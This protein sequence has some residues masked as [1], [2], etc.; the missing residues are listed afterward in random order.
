MKKPTVGLYLIVKDE[1]EQVARLVTSAQDHAVFDE[2]NITVSDKSTADKLSK[3]FVEDKGTNVEYRKWNDRFDEA[4]NFNWAQGST[5]FG[6]WCDADDEFDFFTIPM[7]M[8]RVINE[9]L[10]VIWLPYE[11]AYDENGNCV[12]RHTRERLISRHK[13]FTWRGWVHE[14]MISDEIYKRGDDVYPVKHTNSDPNHS[15]KRNLAILEKAYKETNDP[16]YVHYLGITYFTEGRYQE[17]IDTLLE[18]IEVGGW[19]EEIYRSLLRISDSYNQLDK[20]EEAV[21]FALKA[22]SVMPDYPDAFFT[23]AQIEFADDNYKQC[24]EWLKVAFGKQRPDSPSITDPTI[25]DRA[26]F[27]GAISEFQMRNYS[28]ALKLL[29]TVQTIDTS[30]LKPHYEAEANADKLANILPQLLDFYKDPLPLWN[31]LPDYLKYDNRFRKLRNSVTEPKVWDKK[32]IIIF[33]GKGYE[34]WGPHTLDKGMGGSEEAIVYLSRELVKQGYAVTVYGEVKE[35]YTNSVAGEYGGVNWLPWQMID[36][37]DQFDTL[38]VWRYPNLAG[39]FKANRLLIDMHDLLPKKQVIPIKDATYM[40]KSQWHKD[41]YPNITN[42]NIVSNG[43]VL[44]QF[45]DKAKKNPTSVGYFSAYYRGLEHV[46]KLWP[47]IKE[48]VPEATLDIFYGWESWTSFQGKDDFYKRMTAMLEDAKAL[49]VTEHGRVSHTELAQAMLKTNVWAYPTEF[50]EIFA[51]TAVKANAAH[52]IPVTTDRAALKETAGPIARIL[53]TDLFYT[54]EYNQQKFVDE[55]V[56]ALKSGIT[57]EEKKKQD[58]F[59]KQFDYSNVAR[60]WKDA[61]ENETQN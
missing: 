51:I 1:Y 3:L 26:R 61:I 11:Y 44:D 23:L 54:D 53:E 32:S 19:D 56:K 21:Q 52:C 27:I 12:A 30:E 59:V 31:N 10:D 28:E 2:I 18:Y 17:A 34:E 39:Q 22:T 7:L 60:Q 8:Q 48:Q 43:V 24:L 36:T 29:N 47:K 6:F 41:Q 35:P 20:V 42:Y 45:R 25:P 16:R 37:R 57:E 14:T 5:D 15:S 9:G 55:V 40:F 49:G 13:G 4:R 38:I 50:P 58:D 46:V 33:C